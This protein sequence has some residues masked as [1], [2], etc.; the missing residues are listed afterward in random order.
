MKKLRSIVSLFLIGIL[1]L[2]LVACGSKKEETKNTEE[3]K[4][5][6]GSTIKIIATSEDYKPV[7]EK[8]T[9]ETGIK[10]EFLSM[11]SGEVISRTKA[12][13]GKPMAD[14]WFGG[15]L[16]AFM[17]AK[18]SGLLEK[19][20]PEESKDIKE[21]YKDK[22]GYWIGK[23]L[24]IVGFLVNKD[25]LKEKNLQAPENWQDLVKPEYKNEILMSNP[26]VS[27]TNY[28]VV[29]ALLQQK[30]KDEGWKYFEN[31][32]KNISYYSKRGKDPKLKTT[33]GE[34][35]IGITYIDNSIVKLEKEKI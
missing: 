12:E 9:K 6:K 31:L 35:A 17:D 22:E 21:E 33:A 23:G 5:L 13:G 11:S 15:G 18:D 1:T 34:V 8:F 29:N 26:A 14:V 20:I 3:K 30:G 27:G 7:F 16:D 24:T 19:Y 28:A 25:V 2:G 32:N 10:V 4:D